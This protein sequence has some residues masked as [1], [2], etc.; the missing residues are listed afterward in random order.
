MNLRS[1]KTKMYEQHEQTQSS[2]TQQVGD[3]TQKAQDINML[4]QIMDMIS[5]MNKNMDENNKKLEENIAS[6][7]D[8]NNRKIEQNITSKIEN[9]ENKLDNIQTNIREEIQEQINRVRNEVRTELQ[10]DVEMMVIEGFTKI[11]TEIQHKNTAFE[12]ILQEQNKKIEENTKKL[13]Q[14]PITPIDYTYQDIRTATL[15]NT[16]LQFHGDARV[17]PKVF[18]KR[19]KNYLQ[20][21]N[22]RHNI[23]QVI[24]D[25]LRGDAEAWYQMVEDKYETIEQFETIFL[26]HFWGEY[27]QQRVRLNLF[28]GSYNETFGSSREKYIMRK[29]YNIR[30]LEPSLTEAE[31]VRYLARHFSEDIHNVIITQRINT[32]ETLIEYVRNIDDHKIGWKKILSGND[33]QDYTQRNRQDNQ[34]KNYRNYDNWNETQGQNRG[35]NRN[36]NNYA[37]REYNNTNNKKGTNWQDRYTQNR[38]DG[39]K[40]NMTYAQVTNINTHRDETKNL[41]TQKDMHIIQTQAQLHTRPTNQVF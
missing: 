13:T 32:I 35:H 31:M 34:N 12:Q 10:Q 37:N 20:T 2:T 5:G 11:Q 27:N 16:E 33:R 17:H 15:I 7:M 23:K 25:A 29:I 4:S 22:P 39:N 18:I 38:Q 8:E 36:Y 28:N 24:Q 40:D 19:L 9:F 14:L 41:D 6:K 26:N 3:T 30:H 21:L 1:G